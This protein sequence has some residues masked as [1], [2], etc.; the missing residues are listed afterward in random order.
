MATV[1]SICGVPQAGFRRLG[2]DVWKYDRGPT[3]FVRV[4]VFDRGRL[5]AIA[6]S[7]Y[8]DPSA[9]VSSEKGAFAVR[10]DNANHQC[11]YEGRQAEEAELQ[12]ALSAC[13]IR[14]ARARG[15]LAV[16]DLD[17]EQRVRSHPPIGPHPIPVPPPRPAASSAAPEALGSVKFLLPVGS[18][19]FLLP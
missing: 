2:E 1:A 15:A 16:R 9:P 11:Y 19:K 18:V 3:E 6:L 4:L 13:T 14:H 5:A 12:S 8:G 17:C 10:C 7:G